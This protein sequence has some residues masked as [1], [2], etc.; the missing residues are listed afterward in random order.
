LDAGY[1]SKFAFYI[2]I[3]TFSLTTNSDAIS[4]EQGERFHPDINIMEQCYQ[5]KWDPAMMDG[6][7]WFLQKEDE[8]IHKK[9]KLLFVH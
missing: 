6:Y 2:Q 9:K 5:G 4:Y 3:W 1:P 7:C 8:T